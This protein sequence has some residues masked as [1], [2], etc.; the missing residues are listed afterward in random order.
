M[1]NKELN[2]NEMENVS[3]GTGGSKYPLP[4]KDCCD[5]YRIESGATLSRI[6][7]R[8]NTTVDYLMYINEGIITNRN[9]ITAGRYMYVPRR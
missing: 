6:A 4:H 9:D 1:E 5:V 3:G 8:W 7:G 2:L